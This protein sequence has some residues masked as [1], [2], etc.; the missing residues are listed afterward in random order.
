[1][2]TWFSLATLI[3]SG[4]KCELCPSSKSNSGRV[5]GACR[6]KWS[7]NHPS[8]SSRSVHPESLNPYL[9]PGTSPLVH[10]GLSCLPSKITNGGITCPDALAH[11]NTV[12]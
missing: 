6:K 1:M 9:V 2:M 3:D 12:T 4:S 5:A 7:T 8:N 11:P 10:R